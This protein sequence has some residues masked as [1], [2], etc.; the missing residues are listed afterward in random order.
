M[1]SIFHRQIGFPNRAERY[2]KLCFRIRICRAATRFLRISTRYDTTGT[3]DAAFLAP[4]ALKVIA[5]ML[6]QQSLITR[7]QGLPANH[8]CRQTL[9]F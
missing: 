4:V 3:S 2:S 9:F 6:C 8:P 7:E 1:T 5:S